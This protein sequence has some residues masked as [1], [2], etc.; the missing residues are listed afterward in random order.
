[1][2]TIPVDKAVKLQATHAWRSPPKGRWIVVWYRQAISVRGDNPQPLVNIA[3]RNLD[4]LTPAGDGRH[5]FIRVDRPVTEL[6]QLRLGT[7][8][9]D[10]R[11]TER[12]VLEP[13]LDFSVDFP[14]GGGPLRELTRLEI[15]DA[16]FP[17]WFAG[18]SLGGHA[19]ALP[20]MNGGCLWIPCMELLSRFYGRSQEIKRA[21]LSYPWEWLTECLIGLQSP[22]SG[23]A[24]DAVEWRVRYGWAARRLVSGDAVFLAHLRHSPWT[25]HCARRLYAQMEQAR[26]AMSSVESDGTHLEVDPWFSG[27]ATLR[28]SGFAL[29]D[30]GFLALRLE[31]ASDPPGPTVVRECVRR[32]R[33][34]APLDRAAGRRVP[35]R[36]SRV[37]LE[38]D[39]SPNRRS[40]HVRLPDEPFDIL[41][42]PQTVVEVVVQASETA[43]GAPVPQGDDVDAVVSTAEPS[44]SG[45]GVES[46]VVDAPLRGALRH[47][48]EALCNLRKLYPDRLLS[49]HAYDPSRGFL[50]APS[51][52][53]VPLPS[54]PSS[55][56]R[57][58]TV[59]NRG[60]RGSV[61]L[62]AL[63][64]V[65]VVVADDAASSARRTLYIV[66]IE[67]RSTPQGD[68]ENFR[69]LIFELAP[70]DDPAML[71]EGWLSKLR[72]D[73]VRSRGVFRSE[74][75][76]ACPGRAAPFAHLPARAGAP[77][78][79][80]VR[81]AFRK[82]GVILPA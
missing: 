33:V 35:S 27:P 45:K 58:W 8:V 37:A 70:S 77:S 11:V 76:A 15:D 13:A 61:G 74:L 43:A 55:W 78:E 21:L 36:R 26:A 25:Q 56:D 48:W 40:L 57:G 42:L 50:Y 71:F 3:F 41:G 66:E 2:E 73:L 38:R 39:Q 80:T 1:M 5:E 31:G 46:A 72:T 75:C 44:G 67:R 79:S 7:I 28:V 30:G 19:L 53:L 17:H 22:G 4:A 14:E 59:V 32:G 18:V 65:R 49:I 69:G 52:R 24:R 23:S 63:L 9:H 82:M 34:R 51:P 10:G 6:G 81:N 29:P 64:V 54:P 16:D 12:V 47:V 20:L 62:R 60:P 68:A